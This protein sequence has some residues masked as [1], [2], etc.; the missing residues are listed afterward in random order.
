MGF[1]D[2]VISTTKNVA[3]KAGQKTDHA[4]QL[5]KLKMK[6]A[7]I[8]SE[9]KADKER[10][11]DLAY[12]MTKQG[13]EH[14]EEFD[15]LVA[16][17]SEGYAQLEEVE[18]RKNELNNEVICPECATKTS[19]DNTFCPKC[20]AKLPEVKPAEDEESAAPEAG[21]NNTDTEDKG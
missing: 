3:A 19:S 6:E 13:E 7:Q 17:I 12:R 21:E 1:F 9:I 18:S 15:E 5:S 11:G 16:K 8:N 20:G 2:D 14:S 4:V 10:L